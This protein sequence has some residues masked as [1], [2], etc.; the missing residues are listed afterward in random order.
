M[1]IKRI[2]CICAVSA[3]ICCGIAGCGGDGESSGNSVAEGS[4]SVQEQAQSVAEIADKLKSEISY[5]DEMIELTGEKIQNIMGISEDKYT[6]CKIYISSSGATPEEIA[7]FESKDENSAK[8][9]KDLLEK[10]V[11]NQKNTFTD[12]KPEQAP[13]LENPVIKQKD[14]CVYMCI[15]GDNT[16]AEEIIG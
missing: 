2:I 16:K 3:V 6:E 14:N 8:E 5:D 9:I 15:S 13:K 10:R 11:E 1:K 12:Y 4:S 7:C